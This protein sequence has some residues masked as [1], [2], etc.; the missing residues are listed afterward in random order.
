MHPS[1]RSGAS[2]GILCIDEIKLDWKVEG[3]V[4]ELAPSEPTN[5]LIECEFKSDNVSESA[6]L[7]PLLS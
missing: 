7:L 3:E 2:S 6:V 5:K 4:L 1:N